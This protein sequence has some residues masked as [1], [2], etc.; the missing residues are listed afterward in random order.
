VRR[1][2]DGL[3]DVHASIE[4]LEVLGFVRRTEDV[5]I[6]RVSFLARH[7]VGKPDRREVSAHLASAAEGL[8]ERPIEPRFVDLE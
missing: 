1:P 3:D 5:G 4:P 6:G 2:H 7:R 8:D